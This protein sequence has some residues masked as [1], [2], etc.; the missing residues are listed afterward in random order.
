[1]FQ[2]KSYLLAAT[3]RVL[4]AGI[5]NKG[6]INLYLGVVSM[7]GLGMLGYTA[8]SVFRGSKDEIDLSPKNLLREGLDRSGVLGVFGEGI[9][10]GQK[11]FQ[12]GEVSRYKSRDAFGSVLGPTGG[13]ASQLVSLFNKLN[14]LSSAKGEWTT[15]DAD[16]VM[17]LMPLQ[18]LFY[19]QKI[20]RE[21]AH[22]IAEGLGATPV[23]D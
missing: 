7:M 20:N 9:N 5:Q 2:F 8:S 10:I 3:N 15:K 17:R 16:A 23:N 19:L 1:M 21:L 13:S 12:L 6:D 11:L 22:N 14:P 4:Y 18:N